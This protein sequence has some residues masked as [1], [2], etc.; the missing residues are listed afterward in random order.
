MMNRAL[1]HTFIIKNPKSLTIATSTLAG[2]VFFGLS[3][4]TDGGCFGRI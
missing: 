4:G 3:M 2:R 1:Q